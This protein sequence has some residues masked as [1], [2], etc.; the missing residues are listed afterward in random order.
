MEYNKLTERAQV[1]ILEAENESEKFKHGYVGTEH[2]LLGILKE[3]GYSAELLKKHGIVSENITT[4]IQR[5]LD[6]KEIKYE[7]AKLVKKILSW[8]KDRRFE[9]Y[10]I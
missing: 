6:E 1:V 5:Y 4:M 9:E 8:R 10:G 3:D 7:R 2:M